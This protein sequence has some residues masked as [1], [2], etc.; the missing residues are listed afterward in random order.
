MTIY[1]EQR[2]QLFRNITENALYTH[3]IQ[4]RNNLQIRRLF[5]E[6]MCV[7]IKSPHKHPLEPFTI[8]SDEDFDMNTMSEKLKAPNTTLVD[9]IF[10][11]DDPKELYIALNEF[12]HQLTQTQG[13]MMACYWFEWLLAFET[14]CKKRSISC[15]C[16]RRPQNPVASNM[17]KEVVWMI[18]DALFLVSKQQNKGT[19]VKRVLDALLR[20]FC[21]KYTSATGRRRKSL[22][23]YAIELITENT[24]TPIELIA[25]G[26]KLVVEAVV[27]QINNIYQEIKKLEESPQTD[28]LF[29]NMERDDTNIEKSMRKMELLIKGIA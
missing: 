28:Y 24:L 8:V 26:D 22:L 1:L 18:W 19:F 7:M 16:Q 21:I 17:Q 25:N 29:Q 3:E 9:E 4:L 12:A 20:L 10:M 23:Y 14:F 2:Y 13:T 11:E 5:A 15:Q 27:G 6:V